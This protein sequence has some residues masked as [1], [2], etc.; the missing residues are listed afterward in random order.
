MNTGL[1]LIFNFILFFALLGLSFWIWLLQRRLDLFFKDAKIENLEGFI[2]EKTK[3]LKNFQERL[4]ATLIEVKKLNSV[5]ESSFQK[6]GL[7]RYNPFREEVGGDQS[8]SL[9]LLDSKNKGFVIT[10]IY[11]REGSRTYAKPVEGGFSKFNLSEE[12]S[13]ALKEAQGKD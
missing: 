12:E 2:H 1:I 5:T 8:F 10:S 11:S 3:H 9:A 13:Q 4:E 7:V 6:I